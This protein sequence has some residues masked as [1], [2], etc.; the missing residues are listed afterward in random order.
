M[1]LTVQLH[2]V[3]RRNRFKEETADYPAGTCVQDLVVKFAIPE[4]LLGIILINEV[5]ARAEDHLADGD[6]VA[7]LPILEGG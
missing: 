2:G 7:L 1:R 4:E 3:F 6:V 5:H